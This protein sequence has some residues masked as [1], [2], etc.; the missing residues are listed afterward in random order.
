MRLIE[1]AL[2]ILALIA[3]VACAVP[4]GGLGLIALD[5]WRRSRR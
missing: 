2:G 4:L 5:A 3:I 1:L